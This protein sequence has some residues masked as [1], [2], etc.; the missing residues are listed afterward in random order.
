M[1]VD[2]NIFAKNNNCGFLEIIRLTRQTNIARQEDIKARMIEFCSA[3]AEYVGMKNDVDL[4]V[5][6]PDFVKRGKMHRKSMQQAEML[7]ER[8]GKPLVQSNV[9]A[10]GRI[11]SNMKNHLVDWKPFT[12]VNKNVAAILECLI[13]RAGAE[14]LVPGILAMSDS[15]PWLQDL[16]ARTGSPLH[17][18]YAK[19]SQEMNTILNDAKMQ[20]GAAAVTSTQYEVLTKDDVSISAK[21]SAVSGCKRKIKLLNISLPPVMMSTLT[22]DLKTQRAAAKAAAPKAKPKGRAKKKAKNQQDPPPPP[23][24]GGQGHRDVWEAR[25]I[26]GSY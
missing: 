8:K 17:L 1:I 12:L 9:I 15:L 11:A 22:Q 24:G 6:H 10:V 25:G 21:E 3:L 14:E 26:M 18:N 5:S 13:H 4:L 7:W 2:P 19:E 23:R 16:C 20:V